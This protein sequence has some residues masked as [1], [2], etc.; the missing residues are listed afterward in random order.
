VTLV[1]L[2]LWLSWMVTG[3]A[4]LLFAAGLHL[5][6]PGAASELSSLIALY[7][8]LISTLTLP[9]VVIVCWMDLRQGVWRTSP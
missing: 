8:V 9:H 5:A 6:L 7:L 3:V 4:T 1:R 2:A